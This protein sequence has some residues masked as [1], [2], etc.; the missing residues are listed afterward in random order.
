MTSE[1]HE[2]TRLLPGQ[3]LRVAVDPGHALWVL[4]GRVDLVSPPGWFGET[5]FSVRTP[6]QAGDV[7]V[8][9]RGGWIEVCAL[10]PAEFR[11]L[12][13]ARPAPA[14]PLVARL[15]QLLTGQVAW[16]G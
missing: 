13:A 14:A 15:V 10:S 16:R 7:H 1:L 3:A 8:V 12:P 2:T 4:E 5:V 6:L 11:A 9:E